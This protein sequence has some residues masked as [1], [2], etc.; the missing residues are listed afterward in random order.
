[1]TTTWQLGST[2]KYKEFHKESNNDQDD[3]TVAQVTKKAIQWL[4]NNQVPDPNASVYQILALVMNMDWSHGHLDL[5]KS[6]WQCYRLTLEEYKRF[7]SFLERR[8]AQ[9]EPLQ[10]ILGQWD[11]LDWTFS[12]KPPLLCPR[13]ETEE[14]VLFVERDIRDTLQRLNQIQKIT[15]S[16]PQHE[17]PPPAPSGL[18]ILDI[19]SGTGCIG[20]SLCQLLGNRIHVD[21]IDVDPIAVQTSRE[22]AH[23]I[24]KDTTLEYY[25]VQQCDIADFLPTTSTASAIPN[26]CNNTHTHAASK[27]NLYNFVVSNPPYIPT[28][29]MSTLQREVVEHESPTALCGGNDGLDIIRQIIIK[30]P[31]LCPS[32]AVCWMEVDPSHP[33][34]LEALLQDHPH[35]KFERTYQDLFGNNRFVKLQVR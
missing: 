5:L 11:F 4:E 17:P 7:Q 35:V 3:M 27:T 22:N 16:I 34:M 31:T 14:L 28:H 2:P 6:H 33:S 9:R 19:G 15:T 10:Y 18:R 23:R 21:A 1:M 20:I 12:I 25:H 13:P 30:L 26:T 32:G 29:D 8:V 24:L